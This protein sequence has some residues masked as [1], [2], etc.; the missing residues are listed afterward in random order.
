M[1]P[2]DKARED[3]QKREAATLKVKHAN[4]DNY[5]KIRKI[6]KTRPT[7]ESAIMNVMSGKKEE[8]HPLIDVIRKLDTEVMTLAEDLLAQVESEMIEEAEVDPLVAQIKAVSSNK[9]NLVMLIG[10]G[11]N[12]MRMDKDDRGI[13]ILIAA[14]G[15]LG[16][17]E[18][19]AALINMAKRLAS[20][21][22]TSKSRR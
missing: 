11:I 6:R 4:Q 13:L 14:L 16:A 9:K 22:L 20:A 17:A 3:R 10:N 2:K 19:D 8:E 1:D 15:I 21:G 7:L 12:R 5:D 18:E